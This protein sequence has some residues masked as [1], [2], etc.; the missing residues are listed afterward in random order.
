M[1][2]T[3][4]AIGLRQLPALLYIVAIFVGG[5]WP[6]TG[7]GPS[8]SDKTLHFL[9]FLGLAVALI[10]ALSVAS[11]RKRRLVWSLVLASTVGALL[12]FWQ[13]LL[14]HRSAEFLDWAA[15]TAGAALGVLCYWAAS[16]ALSSWLRKRSDG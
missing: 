16:F 14:P 6:M 5:S 4:G 7:P 9:V 1:N 8:V 2:T 11:W 10:P 13:A 3:W 12:E 15:D